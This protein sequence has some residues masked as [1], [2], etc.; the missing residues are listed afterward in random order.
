MLLIL[1]V[2]SM[3]ILNTKGK[4]FIRN[5]KIILILKERSYLLDYLISFAYPISYVEPKKFLI[6]T[7][8]L[9][10]SEKHKNIEKYN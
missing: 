1:I 8:F 6:S 10:T 2:F 7:F 3:L 4:L 9:D 5:H